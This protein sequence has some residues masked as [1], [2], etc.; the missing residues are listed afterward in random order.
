MIAH[1][2]LRD[3]RWTFSDYNASG[4]PDHRPFGMIIDVGR[5]FLITGEGNLYLTGPGPLRFTEFTTEGVVLAARGGMFGFRVLHGD[6][7]GSRR[8]DAEEQRRREL[9]RRGRIAEDQEQ[10]P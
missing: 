3:G 6:E 10:S 1:L 5:E 9:G 7:A 4:D 2:I 8:R